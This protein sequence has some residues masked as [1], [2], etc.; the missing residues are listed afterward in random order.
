MKSKYIILSILGITFMG[1]W[2][3]GGSLMNSG[4]SPIGIIGIPLT[5]TQMIQTEGTKACPTGGSDYFPIDG[6]CQLPESVDDC[7]SFYPKLKWEFIDSKCVLVTDDDADHLA[8]PP[9][10]V[11]VTGTI[12]LRICDA[13]EISCSSESEFDG[14]YWPGENITTVTYSKGGVESYFSIEDKEICQQLED[15]KSCVP[16]ITL[17]EK[18]TDPSVNGNL[19]TLT[20]IPDGSGIEENVG[21]GP[22]DCS[23]GEINRDGECIPNP[24]CRPPFFTTVDGVCVTDKSSPECHPNFPDDHC[25]VSV[26]CDAPFE[27]GMP[28][29]QCMPLAECPEGFL[30]SIFPVDGND[31]ICERME[32]NI[33][34]AIFSAHDNKVLRGDG[35]SFPLGGESYDGAIDEGR[36]ADALDIAATIPDKAKGNL[37]IMILVNGWYEQL[38]NPNAT[39]INPR[40]MAIEEPFTV[41]VNDEPGFTT[42]VYDAAILPTAETG[43]WKVHVSLTVFDDPPIPS[44]KVINSIDGINSGKEDEG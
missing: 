32:R 11:K 31:A 9:F 19:V 8:E 28:I 34:F 25:R 38:G 39:L 7:Y 18:F 23:D 36:L 43:I 14:I 4:I 16:K 44:F 40:G 13:L 12:A 10:E 41:L 3:I 27:S 37:R 26:E 21:Y 2:M 20:E 1:F 30:F 29:P 5:M 42:F 6:E 15:A 24:N 33:E 22:L 17:T 35:I